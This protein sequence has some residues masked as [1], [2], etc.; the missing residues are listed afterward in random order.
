M[1]AHPAW[2]IGCVHV[3]Q[4]VAA[5]RMRQVDRYGL[6][7]TTEDGTGPSTRW[8]L[9]FT[10]AS[11]AEIEADL[12]ADYEDYEEEAPVTWV[13]LIREEIAEA[14]KEEDPERLYTETIQ[15]AALLVSWA[16]KQ[17][18]RH[19]DNIIAINEKD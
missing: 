3:L 9:P 17:L 1:T 5:E 8:L 18:A 19:I 16:E 15:A 2:Q 11:A 10:S 12:R 6:N 13:H 4:D 7:E 14:F